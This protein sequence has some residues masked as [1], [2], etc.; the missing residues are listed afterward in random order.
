MALTAG[1][2]VA[3]TVDGTKGNDKLVGTSRADTLNGFAG[4]DKLYGRGGNDTLKGYIGNDAPMR[5]SAGEDTIL[6]GLGRDSGYGGTGDDFIKMVGD[7]DQDFVNCGED[8][9]G[10][11][12]DRAEVS[13]NDLVDGT[14]AGALTTTL[15]LSC[16]VVVVDGVPVPQL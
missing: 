10:A 2:A 14:T 9:D 6:G 4:N 13:G 3:K 8:A 12:V 1:V 5:G 11:D 7:T 16:E 15:G